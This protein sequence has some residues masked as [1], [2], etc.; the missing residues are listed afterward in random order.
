[1]LN[2]CSFNGRL[3]KDPELRYTKDGVAVC[4]F[5]IA[6]QRNRK[7]DNDEYDADFIDC[8]TFRKT[9]EFVANRLSKGQRVGVNGR[10]QTRLWEDKQGRTRKSVELMAN[11]VDV[12]DWDNS[13]NSSQGSNN[14]AGYDEEPD[15]EVPF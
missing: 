6:V 15:I 2:S 13:N 9:A 5:T 7:N 8:V 11:D 14:V 3:V 1:M 10:M 12:I 4:N